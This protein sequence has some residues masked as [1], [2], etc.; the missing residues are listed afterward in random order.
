MSVVDPLEWILGVVG[1]MCSHEDT[2]S[3]QTTTF[4]LSSGGLW[5]KTRF[6]VSKYC[7]HIKII[8]KTEVSIVS[9]SL[10]TRKNTHFKRHPA[11]ND[12]QPITNDQARKFSGNL[13]R[14]CITRPTRTTRWI[15]RC[16]RGNIVNKF[17]TRDFSVWIV[18]ISSFRLIIDPFLAEKMAMIFSQQLLS[19]IYCYIL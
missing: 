3:N 11:L 17:T 18:R 6:I 4:R 15:S 16:R 19:R 14:V 7:I 13:N 9:Q 10:S 5:I 8:T 12:H 2:E 1:M